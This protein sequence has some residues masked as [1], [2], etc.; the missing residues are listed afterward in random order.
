MIIL[1]MA[2]MKCCE[3]ASLPTELDTYDKFVSSIVFGDDNVLNI[4]W[5]VANYFNQHTVSRAMAEL[6]HI[7]TNETKTESTESVRRLEDVSFLKRKFVRTVNGF[8]AA[9]LDITV[10]KEMTNWCRGKQRRAATMENVDSAVRE[11][12]YHGRGVYE[13]VTGQLR[14]AMAKHKLNLYIPPFDGMKKDEGLFLF[15]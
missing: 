14:P 8:Y 10:V 12:Y 1:R 7:Y 3:Y 2:Y 9:P 5:H 15:D 11:L 6:G 4:P 13:E